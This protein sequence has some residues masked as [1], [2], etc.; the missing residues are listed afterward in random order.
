[1]LRRTTG[2][3]M[4]A[5]AG[6]ALVGLGWAGEK[7]VAPP[8][9]AAVALPAVSV[10]P[11][12]AK[13]RTDPACQLVFF[14]VLEGLYTDGVPD[15]A[16][17]L[18]VPPDAGGD[19]VKHSFVFRCPLCHAAYEA[20]VLYQNRTAFNGSGEKRSTMGGAF[21]PKVLEG[22]KSKEVRTRV[23]TMGAMIRPWIE[24]RM[25]MTQMGEAEQK[26]LLKRLLDYAAEGDKLFRTLRAEPGSVYREWMFYG[27][28]Q[29]CEAAQHV[30][31]K[32][33]SR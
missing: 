1:M 19:G 6:L 16:V 5:V 15:E 32:M 28:C 30:G 21:D 8:A 26:A 3:T 20:F 7:S 13:W 23:Y 10:E 25:R 18:I 11:P 24:R 17:N 29:A 4:A 31:S 27:G 2:W 22:L 33:L 9:A 14:A 12:S